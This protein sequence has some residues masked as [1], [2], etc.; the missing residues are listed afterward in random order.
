MVVRPVTS[1]HHADSQQ[2]ARPNVTK[3]SVCTGSGF[4][5]KYALRLR[6]ARESSAHQHLISLLPHDLFD[7]I[8]REGRLGTHI[9]NRLSLTRRPRRRQWRGKYPLAQSSGEQSG[10][11]HRWRM[12][13]G[14]T[15]RCIRDNR[16]IQTREGWA[17]GIK[18]VTFSDASP[19]R[20]DVA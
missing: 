10:T 15:S 14:K 17:C 18:A 7:G 16:R 3:R 11:I 6:G 1:K 4:D 12:R 8:R 19:H 2:T 13:F 9:M 20:S 5:D